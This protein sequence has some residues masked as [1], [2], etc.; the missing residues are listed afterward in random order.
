M[1]IAD[2][3]ILKNLGASLYIHKALSK[4]AEKA[5]EAVDYF[6]GVRLLKQAATYHFDQ[7]LVPGEVITESRLRAAELTPEEK[8]ILKEHYG[9]DRNASIDALSESRGSKGK[10]LG[11]LAGLAGAG[12]LGAMLPKLVGKAPSKELGFITGLIGAGLGAHIGESKASEKY[13]VSALKKILKE[14]TQNK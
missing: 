6:S 11:G 14:R 1:G 2:K 4:R 3:E 7:E 5:K 8:E 12:T 10:I 13:S 9:L